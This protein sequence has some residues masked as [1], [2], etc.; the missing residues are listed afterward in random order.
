MCRD[1]VSMERDDVCVSSWS[2]L[3][4]YTLSSNRAPSLR[5]EGPHEFFPSIHPATCLTL[6]FDETLCLADYAT[7]SARALQGHRDAY[8]T[9]SGALENKDTTRRSVI[10]GS[11]ALSASGDIG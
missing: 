4:L 1:I 10:Q 6:P 7:A 5:S 8:Q 9:K 11:A 3:M 2:T